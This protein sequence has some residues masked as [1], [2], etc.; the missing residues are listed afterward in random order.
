[1]NPQMSEHLFLETWG[2]TFILLSDDESIRQ[3]RRKG[4]IV[5]NSRKY[6][7]WGREWTLLTNGLKCSTIITNHKEW[8]TS[9][10]SSKKRDI[11]ELT[12]YSFL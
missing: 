12:L 10:F 6:R 4:S 8:L 11:L 3:P 9:E 5:R 1:M 7:G 2:I